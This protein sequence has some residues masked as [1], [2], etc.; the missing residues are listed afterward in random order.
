[1][2]PSPGANTNT[3]TN[4]EPNLTLMLG[5]EKNRQGQSSSVHSTPFKHA[6]QSIIA[7]TTKYT[8][9]GLF[10]L[11]VGGEKEREKI[12]RR[13]KKALHKRYVDKKY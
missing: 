8:N 7:I 2:G 9:K 1:L 11:N 10:I 12:K 13:R 6:A 4:P 5:F 3:N